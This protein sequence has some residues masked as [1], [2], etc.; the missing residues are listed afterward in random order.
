M[1]ITIANVVVL[2][3]L[4]GLHS[5]LYAADRVTLYGIV[6]A[7]L[8]HFS[9]EG[10]TSLTG[11]IAGGQGQSRWG[12]KGA[13][14]M[15][16]GYHADFQLENGFDI[17]QGTMTQNGRLFGRAAWVGL[18]GPFGHV[19][20]GRQTLAATD[21][22]GIY[23]PFGTGYKLASGGGAINSNTTPRGD[24][25]VKYISP[26]VKGFQ[27]A[28]SYAMDAHLAQNTDGFKR[29]TTT[30]HRDRALSVVAR[31]KH[32]YG[33]ATAYYQRTWLESD[34]RAAGVHHDVSPREYGF[35]GEVILP[36][37]V[38][39]HA[40]FAQHRDAYM[41]GVLARNGG[42]TV[43]FQGG[44]VNGYS[45]GLGGQLGVSRLMAQ[46]QLSDPHGSV[47][48]GNRVARN[49]KIYSVGVVHP[50][51]KRTNLYAYGSYLDG[52]WFDNAKTGIAAKDWHASLLV[53][54]MRHVF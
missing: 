35:G 37:R 44:R 31:Y 12:V 51:S 33:Q 46:F 28:V 14:A 41:N 49:Q 1:K 30:R 39:V 16:G 18:R 26:V 8:Q 34:T 3:V 10:A 42:Q 52:A 13:A 53:V 21:Y 22:T 2:S 7:G 45:V 38:K 32:H 40:G 27:G 23:S 5:T 15:G 48:R 54:G 36:P 43:I 9:V 17:F 6:D 25:T 24:N 11:A 4:I 29:P 47:R 20:L 19:R 50:L